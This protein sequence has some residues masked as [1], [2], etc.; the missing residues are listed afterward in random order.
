MAKA[1]G[2]SERMQPLQAYMLRLAARGYFL[3]GQTDGGI[4]VLF[5]EPGEVGS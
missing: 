2:S 5:G 3:Q 4:S 1:K